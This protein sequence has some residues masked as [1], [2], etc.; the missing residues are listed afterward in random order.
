[1]SREVLIGF[2]DALAAAETV[3]SLRAAGFTPRF[4]ARAGARTPA[5]ARRLGAQPTLMLPAPETDAAGAV[6]ALRAH[7][8]GGAAPVAVMA[9]DDAA[10]W[11]VNEAFGPGA[12]TGGPAV[13]SATGDRAALALD[14]T[15]QIALAEAAGLPPPETRV[16]ERA[17]EIAKIGAFPAILK[18]ARAAQLVN[19]RLARGGA[20]YLKNASEAAAAAAAPP[21]GLLF[22]ALAQ[23]LVRGTGEG[24]F[25][26]AT[27][28]GVACWSAHRRVRMMNPHGSGAS[29][30][31]SIPVD[32]DLRAAGERLI[33]AADWRGPFMIELLREPGGAAHF[34]ELNGRLWGST[35]L[36]RRAGLEY[37]AWAVAQAL[38]PGFAPPT[39]PPFRPL[40]VRHLG[41]ELMHL[42]FVMRGPKSEFHRAGW[43]SRIGAL[44]AVLRPTPLRLFYNRD[45]AARCYFLTDAW[46]T[47]SAQLRRRR[48]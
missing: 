38:D 30:C 17:E 20:V 22:P 10:I 33:R 13:A 32:P 19:G 29:A 37:P 35:A 48:G 9:L 40:A 3:F 31:M 36:A 18:S 2:A 11:L 46:E 28:D 4:F 16:I 26:F 44:A 24:L 42:A 23:P 45:P 1:M 7:V 34:M 47:I 6:A 43:P 39:A 21:V 41:R 25:G 27:A 8:A 5:A 15:R 12:P 14:K